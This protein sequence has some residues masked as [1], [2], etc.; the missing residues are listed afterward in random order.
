MLFPALLAFRNG[1][2]DTI[3]VKTRKK[4]LLSLFRKNIVFISFL[5]RKLANIIFIKR[6]KFFPSISTVQ[7]DF[8]SQ[9]SDWKASECNIS[10]GRKL[11]NRGKGNCCAELRKKAWIFITS[12]L[13]KHRENTNLFKVQLLSD[14]YNVVSF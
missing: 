5:A 10:E 6:N 8:I 11:V 9:L 7:K 3:L 13:T 2:R 1:V 12:H 4:K 14:Q